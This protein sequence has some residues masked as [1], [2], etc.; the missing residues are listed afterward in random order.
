MFLRITAIVVAACV[1]L[2]FFMVPET[3]WDR[4]PMPKSKK[5]SRRPSFMRRRS[6]RGVSTVT[7]PRLSMQ[8]SAVNVTDGANAPTTPG[9]EDHARPVSPGAAQ[10]AGRNT[11]IGFAP[12]F[13]PETRKS[14]AA[15]RAGEEHT[16]ETP[17]ADPSHHQQHKNLHVGFAEVSDSEKQAEGEG[18]QGLTAPPQGD[19]Q[20]HGDSSQPG[21]S[22][23]EIRLP[24]DKEKDALGNDRPLSPTSSSQPNQGVLSPASPRSGP[25]ANPTQPSA[26]Y[27]STPLDTE[28]LAQSRFHGPPKAHGYTQHLRHMPAKTFVQQLKPFNGRLNHDKWFKVMLRPFYLFTYPAV[29]WSAIIYACSVG[30]LIVLSESMAIIYRDPDSYNFDAMQTGLVYISPFVGGILGTG[31]AGKISDII[32]KA[33][34]KRNGGL[35][36]PEFRLVM[37]IPILFSTCIGLMGFGWSAEEKNHWA[38]PTVFF[39]IISFGCSLGSTTAITF[40]VDSYRQYAGEALV[41]LNFAK[42]IFHGLIFSLFFTH[43]LVDDGPKMVFIWVGIIQLICLLFTIPMF[44]YGKRARMW[45]VRRNIM[46]KL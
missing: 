19:S 23:P 36:E 34:S 40:C 33:M 27:F 39:G 31:V 29:L 24:S 22:V 45:T 13:E 44:I 35:Y 28:K 38:V 17:P 4:T 21:Q 1:V 32:V 10:R 15:S 2:L 3:F 30:W 42:N 12:G 8:R 43:W 41:T 26:D 16:F 20:G 7:L 9:A 18:S 5:T 6:S 25:N 14:H 37:A 46:E 11:H